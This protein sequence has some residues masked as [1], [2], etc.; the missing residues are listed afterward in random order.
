MGR[1]YGCGCHL[2]ATVRALPDEHVTERVGY[3]ILFHRPGERSR[4]EQ[5][6]NIRRIHGPEKEALGVLAIEIE[7]V[8][9]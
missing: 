4:S 2:A 6:T 9:A 3:L 5:L 1:V 7:R 8:T